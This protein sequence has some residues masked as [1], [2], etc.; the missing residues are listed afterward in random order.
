MFSC[1]GN[2]KQQTEVANLTYGA[3]IVIDRATANHSIIINKQFA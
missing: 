1:F 2:K 3:K